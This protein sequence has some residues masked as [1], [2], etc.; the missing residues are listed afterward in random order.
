MDP[1]DEEADVDKLSAQYF[2][3]VDPRD[4]RLPGRHAIVRSSVQRAMFEA[5]F[6]E[7]AVWPI[8]PVAYRTQVLKRIIL[9]I[10]ECISNPDE[11]V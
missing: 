2:Q 3:L 11:D 1:S 5:M 7:A 8:P 9:K 6:E 10:E 4:L